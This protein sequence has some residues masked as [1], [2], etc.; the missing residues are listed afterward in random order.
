MEIKKLIFLLPFSKENKNKLYLILKKN[1]IY[2]LK[3]IQKNAY[4]NLDNGSI[5]ILKNINPYINNLLIEIEQLSLEMISNQEIKKKSKKSEP[6]WEEENIEFLKLNFNT[7]QEL[8]EKLKKSIHQVQ[9]KK[10]S[11]GLYPIKI[12]SEQE[13]EFLEQNLNKSLYYLSEKLDRSVASIKAKQR[14]LRKPYKKY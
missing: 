12:W 4:L 6:L 13:I 11:L 10:M 3:V 7:N 8:S 5:V 14:K 1:K 9:M 2:T